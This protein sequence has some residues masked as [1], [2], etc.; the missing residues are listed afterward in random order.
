MNIDN[1]IN[2][3]IDFDKICFTI[4]TYLGL[5]ISKESLIKLIPY[6]R[7]AEFKKDEIILEMGEEMKSIY[8]IL[9]GLTRSYYLDLDGRDVTKSFIGEYNFCLSESFLPDKRSIQCFEALEHTTALEFN[10]DELKQVLLADDDLRN[11]Y[12]KLLEATIVYKM[13]R[14]SGFQLKSATERYIDFKREFP[15]LEDRVNQSYIASYLGITS[16]SLSRIRKN[17]REEN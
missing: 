13:N 2:F 3:D 17:I 9:S 14:E 12:I 4:K 6:G 1:N 8:F 15:N 11:F 5:K 10:A 7:K 16:V